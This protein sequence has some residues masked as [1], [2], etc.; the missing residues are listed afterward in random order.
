MVDKGWFGDGNGDGVGVGAVR[1]QEGKNE[2][3]GDVRSK[4]VAMRRG[5]VW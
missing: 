3:V 4:R 2:S 5:D 1:Q